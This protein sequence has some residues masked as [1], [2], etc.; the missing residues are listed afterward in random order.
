MKTTLLLFAAV[1]ALAAM[2]IPDAGMTHA[3]AVPFETVK[4]LAL[5]RAQAEYPGARLG[6]VAPYV[7][8]NGFTVAYLFHFRTDGKAFPGYEQVAEDVL[9]ERAKLTAN[10]DLT[11][12]TSKYAFVLVSARYDRA[13]ILCFGYGTSEFY[14]IAEAGLARAQAQLGTD[15]RLSRVLFVAPATFLEFENGGGERL[16]LSNHFERSWDSREGFRQYVSAAKASAGDDAGAAE[17]HRREWQQALSSDFKEFTEVYVP[18]VGRAPFYDWSYGCTPTSGAIV[19]G[20]IDRTQNYGRLVDWYWQRW[21]NVEG[22]NDWQIPNT[23]R[24]CALTMHTDT[25]SGGTYVM[26]IAAGLRTAANNNSY[27][28]TVT[29]ADGYSGND[30]A[31]S[32]ITSQI[33]SGY[34]FIWSAMWES[35]SLACF[36]YRTDD[37]YVYVHNTWWAPAVWWAHSGAD[38]SHVASPHPSGG[39]ARKIEITW[40]V[41]D[42]LYNSTGRGEVVQIGD[43][44]DITWNNFGNPG[45]KVVIE[46]STNGGRNWSSVASNAP[47]NGSYTWYVQPSTQACDSVRLRLTQYNSSTVTAADGSFGCFHLTREPL[48]PMPLSPPNGQQIF[49]P[50]IVLVVDSTVAGVDSYDFR[51]A[52]GTDTIWRQRGTSPQCPVP[53]SILTTNRSHK[54]LVRA[55]NQFGWGANSVAWSFWVRFDPSAIAEQRPARTGPGLKV[56]SIVRLSEGLLGFSVSGVEDGRLTLFDATGSKVRDFAVSN[57]SATWDLRD[58]LGRTAEAGLYF[59]RLETAGAGRYFWQPKNLAKGIYFLKARTPEKE[60]VVKVLLVD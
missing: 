6:T 55:H 59:A 29:E 20:Y 36:G 31:W 32:T 8:E 27:S 58:R 7:D 3:N 57:G 43:T 4:G 10:T 46:L 38:D 12:W 49:Q 2:P 1:T 5:R 24:E 48:A 26:N 14:A 28:F 37:K 39:D 51:L 18:N 42:T 47:D 25:N 22:E 13:P 41:G 23:Q 44:A 19:L 35:H 50:P 30:W 21:D 45:T 34:A 56:K 52:L 9:A 33:G 54:W 16:V 11:R 17:A 60:S 40:P 15:A 53:D